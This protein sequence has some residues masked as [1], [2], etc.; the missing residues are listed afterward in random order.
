MQSN[1]HMQSPVY[2]AFLVMKEAMIP[3][4][5]KASRDDISG[6]L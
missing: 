6:R 2:T 4:G 1:L 3:R 5:T